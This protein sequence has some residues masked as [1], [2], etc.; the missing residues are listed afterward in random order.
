MEK[1]KALVLLDKEKIEI[2]EV[3]RPEPN[4]DEILV[5]V[6]ACAIC[7]TTDMKI[8]KG[9]RMWGE[10]YPTLWGHEVTGIVAGLGKSVTEFKIGDR[11]LLRITRAG[12]AQYC[13]TDKSQAVEL[14]DSIGFEEGAIGQLM[15]IAIRG[16]EKSVREGDSVFVCGQG[17]AGLL[18]TQ[19]AKAYGASPVIVA[20]KFAERLKLARELGAD[21]TIKVEE[22][23]DVYSLVR[24]ASDGGVEAAIECV[25]TEPSFRSCEGSL[26]RGGRLVIFGTHLKPICIDLGWWEGTSFTLIIAREQP[27]E[28][29]YLL[30]KTIELVQE[31]SVKL[32]PMLT[33][34]FP[35]EEAQ[36]A[37]DLILNSP[38]KVVKIAL[39]P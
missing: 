12:Y 29:P 34:T 3:D 16:V 33:H 23:T 31:G 5:Q 38:E 15:P 14:P 36:R 39:I 2:R 11:V 7:N 13:V 19:V 24:E 18:C 35:L 22:D 25:G 1:M 30:D 6:K 17:P 37:F 9:I 27:W 32:K 4:D 8:F 20:D 26:K 21:V 28:T 10:S